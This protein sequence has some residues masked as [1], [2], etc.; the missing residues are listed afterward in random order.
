MHAPPSFSVIR[1]LDI[2]PE[3]EKTTRNIFAVVLG[4]SAAIS[5][6]PI[7]QQSKRVPPTN[8]SGLGLVRLAVCAP[9]V[10]P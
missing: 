4:A 2:G 5:Q 6:K 8:N 1:S 10:I 7:Q 3:D 9:V